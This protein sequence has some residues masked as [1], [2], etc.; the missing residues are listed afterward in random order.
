MGVDSHV[1]L[2]VVKHTGDPQLDQHIRMRSRPS[3]GGAS[4]VWECGVCLS[5][6]TR[7]ATYRL[8]SPTCPDHSCL[9]PRE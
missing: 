3:G 9:I 2:K 5:Y 6:V 8:I 4:A 7:V 1:T